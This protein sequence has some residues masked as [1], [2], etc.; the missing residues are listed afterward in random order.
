MTEFDEE[1]EQ[2]SSGASDTYPLSAGSV[3]MNGH[4]VFNGRPCK[5][6]NP[7]IIGCLLL[8]FKDRKAWSCQSQHYRH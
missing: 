6:Y 3:K 8:N 7:L 5:V 2:V 4:M 1:F